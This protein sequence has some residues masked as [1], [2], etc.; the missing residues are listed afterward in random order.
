M[1]AVALMKGVCMG[2]KRQATKRAAHARGAYPQSCTAARMTPLPSWWG[3]VGQLQSL[4]QRLLPALV[5]LL[6]LALAW[7]PRQH[8]NCLPPPPASTLSRSASPWT[9]CWVGAFPVGR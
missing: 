8:L 3:W 7:P 5:A 1:G 6:S 2:V 9:T 4:Q